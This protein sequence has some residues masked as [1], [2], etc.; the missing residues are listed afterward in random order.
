MTGVGTGA[1]RTYSFTAGRA[2]TF[3]YEAGHTANGA[4]QVAMGLAGALVVL[5]ADGSAY[6]SAA[7]YPATTYDDDAVVVLSEI[8]PALNAAPAT[9]DMRNFAPKYRLINGKPFPSTR[10]APTRATRCC[11]ATSTSGSQTHAMSVLGG[12]QVEIAQDGHQQKYTSTV[13]AESVEPGQTLDTLVKMPTG[14]E[15]KL[16]V[17]EPAMHLDNNGQHTA[18]PLQFAFGGM[19]T[20]LDTAAPPP[21]TDG[22]GPVSSHITLS[23]NPSDGLADVTVTADLSDATTGGSPV[24]QAEF[25][26]DDAVTTGVGF[27]VP[28]TGTFGTV[29]VT[30]ATGTIPVARPRH[31]VPPSAPRCPTA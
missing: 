27:G 30:G 28:M 25:V 1:S 13:T 9:F 7:G 10:S 26:V 3:L 18:D 15:A 16:A 20:F 11:C 4:R 2:G 31:L 24:T 12:D 19:L 29:D 23:P 8:D 14:P 6:G 17:Y 22:V 5:P 21:S